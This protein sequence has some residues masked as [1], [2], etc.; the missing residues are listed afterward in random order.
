MFK[1]IKRLISLILILAVVVMGI[2]IYVVATTASHIEKDIDVSIGSLDLGSISLNS[3]KKINPQCIMVLGAS[4]NPDGTPSP[5]LKERLDVGIE[6]YKGGVAPKLLLSGDN[7]QVEYDELSVMKAYAL[8]QGVPEEDIFMD[9]AGFCTYDSIYRA[10]YIFGVER[11][12][13]VTQ[14][15]HLF[16]ALYGCKMMNIDAMGVACDTQ[17]Y[18]GDKYREIREMLARAKD[19]VKWFIK[20]EPK[21]LGHSISIEGDG[22]LTNEGM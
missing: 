1:F 16:R 5:M 13:I 17:E 19:F 10:S 20:P 11:M 8:E 6:L 22:Q 3:A 2:N 12:V 15:Y 9:H 7:G 21:F 18:K 4:V 14:K